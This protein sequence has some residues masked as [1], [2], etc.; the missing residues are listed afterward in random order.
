MY[1]CL[2]HVRPTLNSKVEKYALILS[3]SPRGHYIS[4]N[5]LIG[6]LLTLNVL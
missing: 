5:I 2:I 3:P 4:Y 1:K 6:L